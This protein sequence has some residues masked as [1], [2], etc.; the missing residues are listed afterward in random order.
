MI[1]LR[2]GVQN[3]QMYG[4]RKSNHGCFELGGIG[5]LGVTAKKHKVSY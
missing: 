2:C 4:D 1:A 3:F 5:G